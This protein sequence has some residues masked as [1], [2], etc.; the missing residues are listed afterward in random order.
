MSSEL[1]L[2]EL[3][4]CGYYD[5]SLFS[6]AKV[7]PKR[8]CTMI[9]IEHFLEDGKNI[10]L[11]DEAFPI[12]KNHVFLS[13]PGDVRNCELPFKAKYIKF[14]A[15]G[16]IIKTLSSVP[17]Y[18]NM[19]R[20]FEILSLLDEIITLHAS[21][22]DNE[23]LLQGKLLTYIS[24]LIE[25][26]MNS[27]KT[28]SYK[29]AIT[30]QA[31]SFIKNNCSRQIKLSDIAREVNLSPNYFHTIFTEVCRITP[32]EYLTECRVSMVKNL[33]ITTN[34]PLSEIAERSGFK[35]QQYMTSIFKSEENFSPAQFRKQHQ[36]EYLK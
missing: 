34:L 10:F 28:Q 11:N 15:E 36:N 33:L 8:T 16:K 24:L 12:R 29:R 6:S 26:S 19:N 18:F 1:I 35:T 21:K 14:M 30:A 25:E 2:P 27:Q 23:I 32:R 7:S 22:E 3:L 20:S 9:E 13:L 5:S 4:M 31:Q 17:R